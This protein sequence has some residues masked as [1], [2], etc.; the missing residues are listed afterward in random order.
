M[1]TEQLAVI[2]GTT[3]TTKSNNMSQGDVSKI[4]DFC[5]KA[6]DYVPPEQ[7][8]AVLA[9]LSSLGLD[10]EQSDVDLDQVKSRLTAEE[11]RVVETLH[12]RR[13]I[14]DDPFEVEAFTLGTITGLRPRMERGRLGLVPAEAVPIQEAQLHSVSF[15]QGKE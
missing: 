12:S 13:M 15:L 10:S 7:K 4:F 6:F 11:L 5:F 14:R 1:L 9:K 2:Q 3:D 8:E